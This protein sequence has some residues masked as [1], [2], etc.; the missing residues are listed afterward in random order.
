MQNFTQLVIPHAVGVWV[1]IVNCYGYKHL[2]SKLQ[3]KI[4]YILSE[5]EALIK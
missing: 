2:I 5:G 4:S 1:C 3:V